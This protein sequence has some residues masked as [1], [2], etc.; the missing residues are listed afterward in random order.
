[1]IDQ[2]PRPSTEDPPSDGSVVFNPDDRP[3]VLSNSNFTLKCP[4]S[5]QPKPQVTWKFPDGSELVIGGRKGRA[6][7]LDDGSLTVNDVEAKDAGVYR[8]L[9]SSDGGSDEVD[10]DVDVVGRY[11]EDSGVHVYAIMEGLYL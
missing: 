11:M 2:R 3:R 7:V 4:V 9:V 8:C 1:M 6:T 5:G 10:F